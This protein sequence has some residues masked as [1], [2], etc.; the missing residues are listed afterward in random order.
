MAG[1]KWATGKL[2]GDGCWEVEKSY[3]EGT[4]SRSQVEVVTGPR[5]R[6]PNDTCS[7]TTHWRKAPADSAV[8]TE[9]R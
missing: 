4:L 5:Y 7:K 3:L 9:T 1:R 2:T 6:E 8:R